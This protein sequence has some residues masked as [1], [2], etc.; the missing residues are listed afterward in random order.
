MNVY[1][2]TGF[3]G[4][5]PVGTSAVICAGSKKSAAKTLTATLEAHGL[6]QSNPIDPSR[7]QLLDTSIQQAVI[8]QDGEY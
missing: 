4:R 8:L 1:T 6:P 5:W 2:Y 3:T 7:M